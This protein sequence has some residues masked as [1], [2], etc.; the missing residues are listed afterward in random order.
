MYTTTTNQ[1]RVYRKAW[2][3]SPISRRREREF[4][5]RC[6]AIMSTGIEL[7]RDSRGGT[8]GGYAKEL[9]GDHSPSNS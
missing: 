2:G 1:V 4:R 5:G 7:D 3:S 9:A 6:G 8:D